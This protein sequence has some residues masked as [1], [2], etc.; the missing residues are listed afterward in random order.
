MLFECSIGIPTLPIH[1]KA[2]LLRLSFAKS[3]LCA[4]LLRHRHIGGSKPP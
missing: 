1:G 4:A 3:K 2:G